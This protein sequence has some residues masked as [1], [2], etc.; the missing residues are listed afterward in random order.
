V[1]HFTKIA[2]GFDVAP[3][4]AQLD[5]RPDLW[6]RNPER[7]TGLSPH[8]ETDDM[9]IRY[10]DPA[11]LHGPEDFRGPHE[12]VWYPAWHAL[13]ALHPI[14]ERMVDIIKP[15]R[16]GGFLMTRIPPGGQVYPHHDRGTWHAERYESKIWMPLLANDRCINWVEDEAMIWKPGEAWQHDN[17]KVHAVQNFGETERICLI[18][19]FTTRPD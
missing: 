2:D 15:T 10:R 6:N 1:S 12:S 5:T 19:C 7:R 8:R 3:V 17:L 16:I 13:P 14:V 18:L 4:L 11:N 9:W